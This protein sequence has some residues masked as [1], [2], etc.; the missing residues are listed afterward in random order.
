MADYRVIFLCRFHLGIQR[1]N[2][3]LVT[4][5]RK[6]FDKLV[7]C[8]SKIHIAEGCLKNE[9]V[10]ACIIAE[11]GKLVHE[12]IS[13]LYS[14]MHDSVLNSTNSETVSNFKCEVVIKEM[15]ERAP[16]LLPI[17]RECIKSQDNSEV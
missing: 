1:Q 9:D 13:S 12:E 14:D 17:F 11:V 16:T 5:T 8:G 6:R 10:K 7:A 15:E 3:F 2:F 4:P